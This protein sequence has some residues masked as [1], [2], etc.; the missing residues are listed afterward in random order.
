MRDEGQAARLRVVATR[1]RDAPAASRRRRSHRRVEALTQYAR[2]RTGP[3]R[4]RCDRRSRS[5]CGRP[6]R[7]GRRAEGASAQACRLV[8]AGGGSGSRTKRAACPA[9]RSSRIR[10]LD[11]LSI[12]RTPERRRL[13]F[14]SG[15]QRVRDAVREPAADL[16]AA[17]AG[18][19]PSEGTWAERQAE[20]VKEPTSVHRRPRRPDRLLSALE[21]HAPRLAS[22]G[23]G[24]RLR[25]R[26]R[27]VPEPDEGARLGDLRH[28]AFHRRGVPEAP[29]TAGRAAGRVVRFRRP[30]SRAR[31]SARIRWTR[32]SSWP[33]RCATAGILFVST[34]RLDT[35]P[36]HRDLKY[37]LS[38]HRHVVSFSETCLRGLLA[39]AGFDTIARDR[40]A[41]AGRG[42]Y[43]GKAV[44]AP[45]RRRAEV[46]APGAAGAAARGRQCAR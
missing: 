44:A 46:D 15:C 13:A 6:A 20:R 26:R 40:R 16:G 30:E 39:R 43:G 11:V 18:T 36:L 35:L 45:S 29:S 42:V 31:A 23:K 4:P 14:I 21:P 41:G 2:A 24:A 22:P 10:M 32:C 27:Q 38:G 33:D 5:G 9:C 8:N 7:S 37:C 28:R 34:P 3:R 25:V 12:P 17:A 19:T 1:A